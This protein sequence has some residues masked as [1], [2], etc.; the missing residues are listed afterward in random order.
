MQR[1]I[2][3]FLVMLLGTWTASFGQNTKVQASAKSDAATRVV[4]R[5]KL[6]A[7]TGPV[8]PTVVFTPTA[9]GMY[10]IS[11]V[12]VLTAEGGNGDWYGNFTWTDGG[13]NEQF[14]PI[15]LQAKPG[16]PRYTSWI[17]AARIKAGVPLMFSVAPFD[18]PGGKYNVW[19]VVERM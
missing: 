1:T 6:L 4:A 5:F 14:G 7:Q 17:F 19:V 16:F 9:W 15:D 3:C 12:M 18:S 11:I 2:C 10:R 8:S 13:G